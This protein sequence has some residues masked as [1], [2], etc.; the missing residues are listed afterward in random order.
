M[1]MEPADA[2]DS[3]RVPEFQQLRLP[4]AGVR[5]VCGDM[6]HPAKVTKQA[7]RLI[8]NADDW[9]YDRKTTDRTLECVRC[10]S[11]SSVS[12]MVFMKDSERGA[13]LAQEF[14]VDVGLHLN[15]TERFSA[16]GIST[17]LV[18][19]QG[20]ISRFLRKHRYAQLMFH[21]VLTRS[22]Q[23]VVAAQCEEFSRLY[24]KPPARVDGHHHMHL[25]A[26]VLLGKLLPEGVTVRRN[27]SFLPGEKSVLNRLYRRMSDSVL[28]R[29]HRLTDCFFSLAPIHPT[30]R[31]QRILSLAHDAVVEVETHPVNSEEYRFL[32]DGELLNMT[33]S[34]LI[35]QEFGIL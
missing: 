26:N 29:R 2:N 18:A 4:Q 8:V 25:C 22:F 31:I 1:L 27:F 7:G 33:G 16:D 13:A 12:A 34:V 30:S 23:Y 35:A 6:M 15:L 21:P 19:H 3:R 5:G 17:Q 28:M 9:G 10:G 11:V 14:G 24:G 32:R 20:R